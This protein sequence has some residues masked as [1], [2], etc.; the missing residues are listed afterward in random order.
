MS[1]NT[2]VADTNQVVATINGYIR[3]DHIKKAE[4]CLVDN[5]IDAD[6][7][8][9]V[10]QALGYI[11]LDTELYPTRKMKKKRIKLFY[12][13]GSYEIIIKVFGNGLCVKDAVREAEEWCEANCELRA[14]YYCY[15][16]YKIHSEVCE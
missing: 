1:I 7:A 13:Y 15:N 9:E 12:M 2:S 3:E 8:C 14:G 6:E 5:G 4:R 16:G 11:L 10:L